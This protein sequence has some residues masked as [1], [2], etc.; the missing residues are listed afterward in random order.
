MRVWLLMASFAELE[1]Q[2]IRWSEARQII[3]NSTPLAQSIKACEEIN[4]LVDALRNGDKAEAIDAVGDTVVCLINVCALMDATSRWMR[5]GRVIHP[6]IA[7]PRYRAP[8]T[9]FCQNA[10]AA[11]TAPMT[12]ATSVAHSFSPV[13][14]GSIFVSVLIICFVRSPAESRLFVQRSGERL[15][16]L[17]FRIRTTVFRDGC[18]R[19]RFRVDWGF[20]LELYFC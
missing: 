6:M 1:L 2:V 13:N 18:S 10:I 4:E 12:A 5:A 15:S 14:P 3:P 19:A 8:A 16:G 7:L 17:G 9:I 20:K 11:R